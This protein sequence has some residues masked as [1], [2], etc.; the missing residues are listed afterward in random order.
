MKRIMIYPQVSPTVWEG[1][2]HSNIVQIIRMKLGQVRRATSKHRGLNHNQVVLEIS[3][4]QND[5]ISNEILVLL[6]HMSSLNLGKG[7]PRI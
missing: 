3:S 7:K 5:K 1:D 6:P 4:T 2:F